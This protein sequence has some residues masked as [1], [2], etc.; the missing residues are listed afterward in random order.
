MKPEKPAMDRDILRARCAKPLKATLQPAAPSSSSSSSLPSSSSSA[1]PSEASSSSESTGEAAAEASGTEEG[2]GAEMRLYLDK[3][4]EL[5]P[6]MPRTGKLSRVRLIHSAIDYIT[7]LQ[8]ALEA[9][10]R[11]KLRDKQGQHPRPPLAA[12]PPAQLE[13]N[14]QRASPLS[15]TSSNRLP[16]S[17]SD[18]HPPLPMELGGAASFI[19]GAATASSL[20]SSSS[21]SSGSNN[22]SS[23]NSGSNSSD[24]NSNSNSRGCIS[25]SGSSSGG[26]S[27]CGSGSGSSS[28][29]SI[30]R[31]SS[32]S[33]SGMG[34]SNNS[35]VRSP[36]LPSVPGPPQDPC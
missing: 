10:T 6:G 4:R 11:R 23:N 1:S 36:L 29:S 5:V 34:S 25:G 24:N 22:S 15:E 12:L 16:P 21:S 13:A 35:S 3:L 19:L 7:D 9:R 28:G 20:A 14:T 33:S 17:T 2:R 26:G 18:R 30:S 8:E 32:D 27:S 31:S